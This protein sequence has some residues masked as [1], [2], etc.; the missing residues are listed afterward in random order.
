MRRATLSPTSRQAV[1]LSLGFVMA[2]FAGDALA[3]GV[4][5]VERSRLERY[6]FHAKTTQ[7][8]LTL[9]EAF[10]RL[11]LPGEAKLTVDQAAQVARTAWEW[12]SVATAYQRLGY[13]GNADL[14]RRRARD[15]LQ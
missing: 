14:A 6:R 1:V 3:Q 12:N 8:Y 11:G 7:Q 9:A 13:E 5:P 2:L 15:A 4:D 10:A